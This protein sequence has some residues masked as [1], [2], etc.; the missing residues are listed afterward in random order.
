[1][2]PRPHRAPGNQ[3]HSVGVKPLQPFSSS[4]WKAAAKSLKNLALS[5][6]YCFVYFKNFL[7]VSLCGHQISDAPRHR[8]DVVL[9][10]ASA[11]WRV[12][13]TPI[14]ARLP[15]FLRLLHG[16]Q[17]D[18]SLFG[19]HTAVSR[20]KSEGSIMS[21]FEGSSYWKGPSQ[22]RGVHSTFNKRE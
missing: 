21:F 10:T 12:D 1:M 6:A 14:D 8:R 17:V 20:S 13:S 4:F 16:V 15:P 5:L 19:F 18:E 3:A 9:V 11:R 7:S 22:S 2:G